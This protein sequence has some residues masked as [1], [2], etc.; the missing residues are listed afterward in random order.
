[1]GSKLILMP[2]CKSGPLP[3]LLV[4]LGSMAGRDGPEAEQAD[5]Y[6]GNPGRTPQRAGYSWGP[7]GRPDRGNKPGRNGP[8][9]RR[10]QR[11]QRVSSGIPAEFWT[12]LQCLRTDPEEAGRSFLPVGKVRWQAR[13]TAARRTRVRTFGEPGAHQA[14]RGLLSFGPRSSPP[15]RRHVRE[16][17]RSPPCSLNRGIPT[18]FPSKPT[19][20]ESW[21]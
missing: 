8:A 5:S 19:T 11:R 18:A 3:G 17:A 13:R 10:Y 6:Y 2:C 9:R 15:R 14:I 12:A 7:L 1:M 4:T 20:R 21:R 16:V